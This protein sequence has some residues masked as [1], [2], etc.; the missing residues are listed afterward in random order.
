MFGRS[1]TRTRSPVLK[2]AGALPAL[3]LSIAGPHLRDL[4]KQLDQRN[5]VLVDQ[6][7]G[8]AP[9]PAPVIREFVI[10]RQTQVVVAATTPF[11][12][13]PSALPGEAPA[14]DVGIDLPL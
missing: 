9:D 14:R 11:F 13:I 1:L 5:M 4:L 10:Q 2:R 7:P 6:H 3:L 12:G 8:G